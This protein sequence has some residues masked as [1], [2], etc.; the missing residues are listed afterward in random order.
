MQKKLLVKKMLL[1]VTAISLYG[2]AMAQSVTG[3]VNG[4]N[5]T[6]LSG[7]SVQIKNSS[8]GVTTNGN[9]EFSIDAAQGTVLVVSYV[10]HKSQEVKVSGASLLISL[11]QGADNVLSDVVVVGYGTQKRSSVTGAILSVN[12][13]VIKD[14]PVTNTMAALQGAV[15]GLVITR[16]NGQPGNEKWKA[17]IRGITSL[18]TQNSPL[19]IIDGVEGELESLN[20]ND[21]QNISVLE[22]AASA[23]IY[24]AKAGAGVILVTT[25]S[26]KLNQKP[27]LELSSIFTNR[28]PYARPELISSADQARLQNAAQFNTNQT[29]AF[30][31]EQIKWMDDP[32]VN[33]IYNTGTKAWDYY[34]NHNLVDILMRESSPQQNHNISLSG[35]T[36]KSNYLFSFGYLSQ[37]GVFNFGPDKYDRYNTRL[38]YNTRF[39]SKISLD[40]RLAFSKENILAPSVAADGDGGLI[41]NIYSI[42]AARN[43]IFAPGTTDKYAFIGT[44]S[45]AYPILKDGGYNDR[46]DYKLNGVFALSAKSVLKGLDLK[47]VYSPGLRVSNQEI[48]GRT[49][50][51]WS[52]DPNKNLIAGTPINQTNSFT[53]NRNNY[54]TQN[55]QALV[56]YDHSVGKHNFHALGGF[57]YRYY[58]YDAVMARQRA[59]LLND[60][61][62]LNYTTLANADVS[63]VRD[64][65]QRNVWV[66]YFG[67]LTYNFDEKYY[68]EAI[69]RNDASS[70][71][72]PG[73]Q[74]HTF[75]GVSLAWRVSQENWFR[76]T[77]DWIDELKLRASY[78][79][80]GGAQTADLNANNYDFQATLSAGA[81]PFNDA[82]T[83]YIYQADLPAESKGW[84]VIKTS[85]VGVDVSMLR[86]RLS[87]TFDYFVR[88]NDDVFAEVQLPQVL[89]VTPN[90]QNIASVRVKGWGAVVNW[91]DVFRNGSYFISANLSDNTNKVTKYEGS[92]AYTAGI[93]SN[94]PGMPVNSIFGYRTNGYFNSQDELQGAPVLS[95]ATGVGDIKYADINKDGRITSG[96]GTAENHGDLVYL[97]NTNSRYTFGLNAGI[98]WKGFDLSFLV[99]G[100]GKRTI[101]LDPTS[102]IA[103][104][105]SWRMPWAIH[106]DYWT[107]ENT[108]ARFP[109]LRMGDRVNNAPSSKWIQDASYIRLKN[110]QLGYTLA[111][112]QHHL[113]FI[114]NIRV[115]VSGQDLWEKTG[116]W[117]D[118]YDPENTD[119]ISF[120]Y[121]LWRSYSVGLN[122]TF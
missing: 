89:G 27:K 45:N 35:G 73:Y 80:A 115:Y 119:R 90:N 98:N 30:T 3:K 20:P 49:V 41:Y 7:V 9:G 113:K 112:K 120:S 37:K 47:L 105:D 107:P 55:L 5:N 22:D 38:N 87:L 92:F 8:K 82:R 108:D 74:N 51:R 36:D 28:K 33:E 116:M 31:D 14:R 94:L 71:L 17:Q 54:F 118:Y 93:N 81:Y 34:Y 23:A 59:L 13:E 85:N 78:G 52:I 1:L 77:V 43:P 76:N 57:E 65:I 99:N 44:I 61:A 84:E 2:L 42:R 79:T 88:N 21:I 39:N 111:R 4:Q 100:V 32:D 114:D 121:P 15:P 72:A 46:D 19:I 11:E 16:T 104:Y 24:G 95:N 106:Q 64:N 110:L 40:A 60:F 12:N 103:F 6:P 29:T 75:P 63:N 62:T 122:V 25:K 69:L 109:K 58:N 83:A 91:K 97:G 10:G 56:D 101:L 50:P 117:F 26:G 102:S 67:R 48:F 86:R 68:L 18:G 53:K 70:R 66:S 96:I